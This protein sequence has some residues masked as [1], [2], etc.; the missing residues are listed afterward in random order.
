MTQRL[1][2]LSDYAQGFV[3]LTLF[4]LLVNRPAVNMLTFLLPLG[5][6]IKAVR[7]ALLIQNILLASFKTKQKGTRWFVLIEQ[8][9]LE[10]G[11]LSSALERSEEEEEERR[12]E[13]QA[14]KI[15][16]EMTK[17]C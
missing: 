7:E 12:K 4:I 1:R 10:V 16:R 9:A 2:S 6:H 17:S 15:E 8:L 14:V 11:I 13:G 5:V 3:Q